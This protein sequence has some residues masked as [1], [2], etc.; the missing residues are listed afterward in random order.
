MMNN[1]MFVGRLVANP[2]LKESENQRNYT[3]I[4][5]AIPRTFKNSDGVYETDFVPCIL[6]QDIA[7]NT[8]EYCKKG[9]LLGVKGRMQTTTYKDKDGNSN[10]KLEVIADRVTFLASKEKPKNYEDR[11][12]R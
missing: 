1:V 11:D 12:E 10:V 5:L 4:T 8:A 2:E 9:D 7:K 3:Q 6:W